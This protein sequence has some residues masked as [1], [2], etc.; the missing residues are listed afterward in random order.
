MM[1]LPIV[2]R[3][4]RVAARRGSTYW[5]R[6]AVALAAVVIGIV[7]FVLAMG[8]PPTQTGR[9]IFEWLSGLLLVYCLA[10][11]GRSTADCLSEE[12]R[13]G[14][15]G[16]LFLT[17]L[18]GHDVVLGKLAATSLSGFYGLLAVVPVLALPMLM[19]GVGNAEFWRVVLVLVEAFLFSLA[20]GV[21]ASAVSR[22]YRRA[23]GAN[24][25][26]LLVLAA[27]PPACAAAIGYFSPAHPVV[28]ELFFSCPVYPFVL[29]ADVTYTSHRVHFWQSVAVIHAFTWVLVLLASWIAPR[30]WQDRPSV[31]PS[32][33]WRR[34]W[35]AWSY[36]NASKKA[37]FRKR[38]LDVNAFYW[39]AS[40][41]RLK[42]VHV[43]TFLGCMAVWWLAGCVRNGAL[44]FDLSVSILTALL[45]NST[46]KV[47]TAIEAGQRLAEDKAAG[48]FELL[49]SVPLSVGD[50]LRGQLLALRRQF[51]GPLLAVIGVELLLLLA[52]HRPSRGVL[53]PW[54]FVA[55]LVML[56]AD[57]AALSCVGMWR[58]LVAKSH[59]RATIGTVLRV[60]VVPWAVF[61]AVAASG[62]LWSW[63]VQGREWSPGEVFYLRLWLGLGLATDL[64]F[65][66]I[67]RWQLRNRFRELA[68]GAPTSSPAFFKHG[69]AGEEAGAPRVPAGLATNASQS[70]RES[71]TSGLSAS[72]PRGSGRS[73]AGEFHDPHRAGKDP[74][75][76]RRWWFTRK[77]FVLTSLGLL[78]ISGAFIRFRSRSSFPP[79]SVV[80]LSQSNTTLRVFPG[81]NGAFLILPDGSLWRWGQAGGHGLSR[82]AI[83]EQVGTNCDWAQ[84]VPA[85]NHAVGLRTN[86]TLW[87]WGWRPSAIGG[88]RWSNTPEKADGG[89]DWVGIAASSRHSVALRRDGTLWAWG[90]N[91]ENQLGNG[92]GPAQTNLVQV[93]TNSDWT[94]VDCFWNPATLGLRKDGTLWVWGRIVIYGP[95]GAR[96]Q[97]LPL[98]T[99]VCRETNWAGF[100]TGFFPF[101]WT[102]SGEL[103]QLFAGAPNPDAAAFSN[104]NLVV[105]NASPGRV[106]TAFCGRP[107][108]Y[109]ARSDGTLWERDGP[110]APW[111]PMPLS[112][113]RRVGKRSDWI[114][115]W[116]GGGTAFGLTSDGTLW[117]WGIDAGREP[118]PD[119]RY[120]LKALQ[121]RLIGGT[122]RPG[123]FNSVTQPY[124]KEPRPL[125]RLAVTNQPAYLAPANLPRK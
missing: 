113:W 15:L 83:P 51:L 56:V 122:A 116:G 89:G 59:N 46:L 31:A 28:H 80:Q 108:V 6:L 25:A 85:P 30:S 27:A 74:G 84:A 41:A 2:Q 105:S 118:V 97:N 42:P 117:T 67:A 112:D 98:L 39:L 93:G 35:R 13:Q 91:S 17:D 33:G 123:F 36:G 86:G 45:L 81:A 55:G 99:Q 18:E 5:A 107:K 101:A 19:G 24:F 23:M 94:A 4:L 49:L 20:I 57:M 38:L 96:M 75:A 119:F 44:W 109:Q 124:Q 70:H 77:A 115:L 90:D 125:M 22:D 52:P 68:L 32:T 72:T 76:P 64:I 11:V 29:C 1:L 65:G 61:G 47:W 21:L 82:A 9:R 62:N 111:T 66:A 114:T 87:E 120:R 43:W 92:P 54:G 79:P 103:W 34:L 3:E 53:M 63:L 58:A 8:L 7:V 104:C 12:K 16:L 40:R 110:I 69:C 88:G 37:G 14:T 100:S 78:I 60:L 50:I 26:L 106:A 95:G 102:R 10:Y 71:K 121:A 73:L 48:A